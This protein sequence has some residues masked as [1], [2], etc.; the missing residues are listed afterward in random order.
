MAFSAAHRLTTDRWGR[1]A[2]HFGSEEGQTLAEY[3]VLLTVIAVIVV[4]VA[5]VLGGAIANLYNAALHVI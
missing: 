4:A 5:V 2:H 3:V 1:V